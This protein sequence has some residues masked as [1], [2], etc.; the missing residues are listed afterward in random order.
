MRIA[1]M[2]A[3]GQGG[4]YG[5]MLARAGEDVTFIARGAHLEAIKANGLTV[6]TVDAGEFTIDA[7]ATDDPSEIGPVDLVMF[8]VKTY[9]TEAAAKQIR[10]IVG[11]DTMVGVH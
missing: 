6:K 10:S 9:D 2:G 5:G 8:C 1:I 3:G 11:P 7:K 4:Y